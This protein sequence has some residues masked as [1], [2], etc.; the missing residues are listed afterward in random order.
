MELEN[1]TRWSLGLLLGLVIIAVAGFYLV[2]AIQSAPSTQSTY[3]DIPLTA[4]KADVRQLKGKP[5]KTYLS[6]DKS[7][8][9]WEY[10]I[11]QDEPVYRLKFRND[12]VRWIICSGVDQLG[13][14]DIQDLNRN[15]DVNAV[16]GKFGKPSNAVSSIDA[17]RQTISYEDYNV[18]FGLQENKVNVLGIYNPKYGSPIG[19]IYAEQS[20]N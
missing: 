18:M 3:W 13:C 8:E 1:T 10:R 5:S 6:D 14:P 17:L 12:E 11:G 15:S 19:Y 2:E 20:K 7:E 16:L 4:R 9:I